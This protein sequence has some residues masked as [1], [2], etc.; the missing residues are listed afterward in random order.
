[1]QI[2]KLVSFLRFSLEHS[3]RVIRQYFQTLQTSPK[4]LLMEILQVI[5]TLLH[6]NTEFRP[7][8]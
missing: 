7:G 6:F 1:M 5:F 3:I 4:I 2:Q 8:G